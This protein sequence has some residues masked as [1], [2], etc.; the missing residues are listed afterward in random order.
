MVL[1]AAFTDGL[2]DAAQKKKV[3]CRLTKARN[4]KRVAASVE[5]LGAT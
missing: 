5:R 1:A 3:T 4:L 2:T